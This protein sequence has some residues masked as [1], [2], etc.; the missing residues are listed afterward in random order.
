MTA[1]LARTCVLL[2]TCA[3][4]AAVAADKKEPPKKKDVA[5]D[6]NAPRADARKVTFD[7][8]EGTWM[9]VDVSPDGKTLV[10]DLLGDIFAMPA[11]GGAATALT[12]GPAWDSQPRFSPDGKTI[13]FTSD[14][15]GI[16]NIWLMG[17]DGKNPRALT[18]EKDAYVRTA[19]LDAGRRLRRGPQG[20][21]QARGPPARGAVD[22]PPGG[23]RPASS[24]PRRTR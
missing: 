9:S 17:A 12:T 15:G 6:I 16:E 2:L 20:G 1:S 8:K 13:A 4:T 5:A 23:R 24:S 3:A 11:G 10:F 14:R 19:G 22:V 18:E 21:R 7:L